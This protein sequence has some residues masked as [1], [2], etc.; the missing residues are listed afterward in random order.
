MTDEINLLIKQTIQKKKED[1]QQEINKFWNRHL[2]IARSDIPKDEKLKQIE[3]LIKEYTQVKNDETSRDAQRENKGEALAR[4]RHIIKGEL[5][6]H[7]M[8]YDSN[9]DHNQ[10]HAG[11]KYTSKEKEEWLAKKQKL[12][13][14]LRESV[15]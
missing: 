12:E 10:N 15:N 2:E 14:E 9:W 3:E 13:S 7:L 11:G 6:Q 5:D 8:N 4:N 1:F